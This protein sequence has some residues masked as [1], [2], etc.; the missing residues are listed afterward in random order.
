[1]LWKP[2]VGFSIGGFYIFAY[3]LRLAYISYI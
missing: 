2:T 1:M 3:T